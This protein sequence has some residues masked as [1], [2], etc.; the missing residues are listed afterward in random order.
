MV[1]IVIFVLVLI[2]VSVAIVIYNKLVRLR[3]TVR[4]SW[5]DI[6]VQLKKRFNL[7]PS[8]VETVKAYAKHEKGVFEKV[9]EA[10]A[11]AMQSGSPKDMARSENLFKDTL[12][13][14]FA[15]AEAYPDLKANSNFIQLQSQ[16]QELEES[17]E[18]ARRYYNAVVRDYN[19]STETFPS[20]IVASTFGFKPAE[21]F[22]IESP[23]ERK[24]IKPDFS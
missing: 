18:S 21:F 16:F 4:S 1:S 13:S 23:E 2:I 10:R 5:S 17:I 24:P 20:V 8:L 11:R 7:V 3:N 14:L 15:V 22:E 19:T 6:D 9:T 12:K